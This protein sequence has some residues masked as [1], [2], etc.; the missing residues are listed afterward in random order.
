MTRR[1]L[2][3]YRWFGLDF[4][5]DQRQW[6]P[7][8]SKS[9]VWIAEAEGEPSRL[10]LRDV[11]RV[12]ELPGVECR[13]FDRL[14][15]FL[16]AEDY[17]AAGIDAP[18]SVPARFVPD[19]GH[20]ALLSRVSSMHRPANHRFP[21]RLSFFHGVTGHDSPLDPPHPLRRT[22]ELWQGRGSERLN[23]RSTLWTRERGGA[24]MTSACL[25]LLS[26]L[27][28]GIWPW[29]SSETRPLVVEAFPAA[30]LKQWALPFERYSNEKDPA[31]EQRQHIVHR[32]S[33]NRKVKGIYRFF[34]CPSKS[35][36]QTQE[37]RRC[38]DKGIDC[39]H[40]GQGRATSVNRWRSDPFNYPAAARTE[41]PVL[42][43]V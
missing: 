29:A 41:F 26:R 8:R 9:I 2:S 11:R 4:S 20:A 33:R 14:V 22:E 7:G 23:V 38:Q 27:H 19:P 36:R 35:K 13:A 39:S 32:C 18:F 5:G 3:R 31:G 10:V 28:V 24:A 42:G 16:N 37:R 30:Q 6:G 12:Q 40:Q 17:D 21:D 1:Q 34:V 43:N 25:M 15:A